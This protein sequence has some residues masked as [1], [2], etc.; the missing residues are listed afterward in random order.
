MRNHLAPF[1]DGYSYILMCIDVFSR[2]AFA[3]PVKDKRGLTVLA[4]FG[5]ICR[6]YTQHVAHGSRIGILE[7]VSTRGFPRE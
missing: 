6:S 5:K 3:V 4:A 2:Y 1:N 7:R